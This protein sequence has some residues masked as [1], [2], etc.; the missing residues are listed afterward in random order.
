MTVFNRNRLLEAQLDYAHHYLR[1]LQQWQALFRQTLDPAH[2]INQITPD[3]QQIQQAQRWAAQHMD[4]MNQAARLCSAF[5]LIDTAL[6]ELHEEGAGQIAW[7]EAALYAAARLEDQSA[8]YQHRYALALS[9]GRVGQYRRMIEYLTQLLMVKELDETFQAKLHNA[10]GDALAG[11][12]ESQQAEAEYQVA[13]RLSPPSS[14][15]YADSHW[16]LANV[17]MNLSQ[18][19]S[20]INYYTRC[21]DLYE[22]LGNLLRLAQTYT[23]IGELAYNQG[24]YV[25]AERYQN[26]SIAIAEPLGDTRTLTMAYR[27]LGYIATDRGL[28]S[29]SEAYF[30]Q[31]LDHCRRLGDLRERAIITAGLGQIRRRSGDAAGAKSAFRESIACCE[32]TGDQIGMAYTLINLSQVTQQE[33]NIAQTLRQL[34]QASAILARLGDTWGQ[35]KVLLSLGELAEAQAAPAQAQTYFTEMLALVEALGDAR[36]QALAHVGLAR[37]ALA[38]GQNHQIIE[39]VRRTFALVLDIDF[40]PA[41]FG[42][43]LVLIRWWLSESKT[44]AHGLELAGFLLAN[45]ALPAPMVETVRG[46]ITDFDG[47]DIDEILTRGGSRTAGYFTQLLNQS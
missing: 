16:G 21:I 5:G 11:M 23:R 34:E 20:A 26:L 19:E 25:T 14:M 12:G 32:Q 44:H 38:S 35:A 47:K 40:Q 13:L 8:E 17:S 45:P 33:G 46:F 41:L 31:S 28:L 22:Q 39:H 36:G 18:H 43:W 10:I 30:A 2:L 4:K 3:L 27:N 37:T 42:V 7:Y 6:L 9:Y 24:D 29:D 15:E 1:E